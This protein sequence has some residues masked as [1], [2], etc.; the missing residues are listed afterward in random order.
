M[1]SQ[2][3]DELVYHSNQ[4]YLSCRIHRPFGLVNVWVSAPSVCSSITDIGLAII[5]SQPIS[6]EGFQVSVLCETFH[7][8]LWIISKDRLSSDWSAGKTTVIY[9]G[10]DGLMWSGVTTSHSPLMKVVVS[11]MA[12]RQSVGECYLFISDWFI[13][14]NLLGFCSIWQQIQTPQFQQFKIT[15]GTSGEALEPG[16]I[17]LHL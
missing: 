17:T 10:V 1:C 16:G 14:C 4:L 6:P 5:T 12:F 15:P 7:V 8:G 11:V 13:Q 2:H 9:C 3:I